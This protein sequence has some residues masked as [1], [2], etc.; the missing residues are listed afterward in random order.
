MG[1]RG[2][3]THTPAA[4]SGTPRHGRSKRQNRAG[5]FVALSLT[6]LLVTGL[7][8]VAAI[9]LRLHSNVRRADTTGLLGIDATRPPAAAPDPNDPSAG[10]AVN[11]LLIGSDDRSGQNGA[12]G[13]EVGG[14]RSDTTIVMHMSADRSRVELVSIP[15]DTMVA[16]PACTVTGGKK[17]APASSAMFNSAFSRGADAGKDLV[18][19]AACTMTTVESLTNVR[20]N[21]FVAVDFA[22]F[23]TMI[24]AIGGV[25]MC[26][27]TPMHDAE[28]GLNLAAGAQIL[29]GQQA[30][31]LARARYSLSD[32]SD[33]YRMGRQQAL[34]AATARSVLEKN[35]L[36]NAPQLLR[37]VD[38]ATKSVTM[39]QDL[40][41][42]G[43]AFSLRNI[44]PKNV[45]FMTAPS[46]P[47][48]SNP[49]RV[50]LAAAA[51]TVWANM[52][53]DRPLDSTANGPAPTAT[54]VPSPSTTASG[55]A[56]ST[57]TAPTPTATA[58]SVNQLADRKP[59]TTISSADSETTCS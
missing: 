11:I 25:P 53:A 40:S 6:A 1:Q 34:L 43:L 41:P 19:A 36:T 50:V 47:M 16:I 42:E 2:T 32:G 27:P 37:F 17:T 20:L 51:A 57:R 29:D 52:A 22:G 12:I 9:A 8:G 45:T 5:R 3:R 14:M 39:S 55:P 28:S 48:P 23:Q 33:T 18:S 13:G 56:G 10:V 46:G 59:G 30:L 31:S 38:A 54:A 35:V 44:K 49:G 24:N 26:I 15:R 7:S 58:L 21:G 4:A